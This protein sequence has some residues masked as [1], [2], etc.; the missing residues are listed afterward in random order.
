LTATILGLVISAFSVVRHPPRGAELLTSPGTSNSEKATF[1]EHLVVYLVTVS[2]R[3]W[4][5][6]RT[7][8]GKS[9]AGNDRGAFFGSSFRFSPV[10]SGTRY[11][12]EEVNKIIIQIIRAKV[13]GDNNPGGRDE[14]GARTEKGK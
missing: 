8:K 2:D 12:S 5:R 11:D 4:T 7:N 6:S 10:S 1:Y 3:I 13:E 14:Q 9:G